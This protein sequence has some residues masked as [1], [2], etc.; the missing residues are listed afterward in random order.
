MGIIH[1]YAIGTLGFGFGKQGI[2]ARMEAN[3]PSSLLIESSTS[4]QSTVL[5]SAPG[6]AGLVAAAF[7]TSGLMQI[8]RSQSDE[9]YCWV[10]CQRNS[11]E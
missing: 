3:C 11:H 9:D 7:A 10:L 8:Q 1:A 2:Q 4:C 6:R 5:A